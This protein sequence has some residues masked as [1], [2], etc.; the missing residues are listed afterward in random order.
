MGVFVAIL[1]DGDGL[2]P[3]TLPLPVV[4]HITVADPILA[5]PAHAQQDDLGRETAALEI[6]KYGS[7]S[8]RSVLDC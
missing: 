1:I 7:S 4:K 5:V 2:H 3:K 6:D 8:G